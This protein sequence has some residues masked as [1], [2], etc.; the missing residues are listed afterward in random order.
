MSVI[1]FFTVK[2]QIIQEF[3]RF[4][5]ILHFQNFKFL[6]VIALFR[7]DFSASNHSNVNNNVSDADYLNE[8]IKQFMIIDGSC[9]VETQ[10]SKKL[11][12]NSGLI[13]LIGLEKINEGLGN[14]IL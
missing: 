6:D 7:S 4:L 1:N 5:L 13:K 11:N 14:I 10:H 3:T 8:Y 9:D 2:Y 12:N